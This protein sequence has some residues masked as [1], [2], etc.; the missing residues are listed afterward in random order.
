[1]T[2][3]MG[4]QLAPVEVTDTAIACPY[5]RTVG[6]VVEVDVAVRHNELHVDDG[7]VFAATGDTHFARSHFQCNACRR[8]VQVKTPIAD[9]L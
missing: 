9:W 8:H 1:M 2:V 3:Q 4:D 7:A 6:R 5:C